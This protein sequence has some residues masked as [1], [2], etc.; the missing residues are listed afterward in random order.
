V[1]SKRRALLTIVLAVIVIAAVPA[2]LFAKRYYDSRYV[3]DDYFY[4]AVPPDYDITPHRDKG[5]R[6]TEY[7]LL[8]YNSEG[9]ARELSF[10]VLID[11]H[12][13][14]LYPP[15]TFIRVGV[16]KQ[17]VIGRR[18]VDEASVPKKA[19]EKI[20]AGFA[21][22][23]ATSLSEYAEERARRLASVNAGS[24][25]VS[26]SAEGTALIYHYVY[27]MAEKDLAEA[28]AGL[29]DPVYYV[30]FR[31]DKDAVAELTAIFLK[32]ELA[33]G[34]EIFSQ[35]YDSRVMFDYEKPDNA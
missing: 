7:T 4:S 21:Y 26:C 19:L 18:A 28:G 6:V 1:R 9:E 32:I 23:T 15:G 3:L 29:L 12:N 10:S 2:V 20:K 24:A 33:D 35:K 22:T 30:Q 13:S 5:G 16:S 31:A 14:D 34:T 8:C 27:D 25:A 11:A 17:L